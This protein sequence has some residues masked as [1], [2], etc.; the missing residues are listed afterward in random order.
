M[1][2]ENV[3]NETENPALNEGDVIKS[4]CV[5]CGKPIELHSKATQLCPDRFAHFEQTVL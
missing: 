4:V 2:S 3:S 1:N 5:N